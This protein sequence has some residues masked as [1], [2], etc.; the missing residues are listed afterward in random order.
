MKRKVNLH[1]YRCTDNSRIVAPM[2]FLLLLT[3]MLT[4]WGVTIFNGKNQLDFSNWK[5]LL[6]VMIFLYI[7]SILFIC[8]FYINIKVIRTSQYCYFKI[9]SET[10]SLA[11]K[12]GD[13]LVE[14]K[15]EDIIKIT[16]VEIQGIYSPT[17][18]ALVDSTGEFGESGYTRSGE[19]IK[20]QYTPKR[21]KN[22]IKFL[23]DCPIEKREGTRNNLW[24]Y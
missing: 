14:H 15:I 3:E 19:Y 20:L 4:I 21:I 9:N 7:G 6:T 18:M 16:I 10:V 5:S 2:L 12:S 8:M 1:E 17:F 24:N 13:I 22:I 23:P 11:N